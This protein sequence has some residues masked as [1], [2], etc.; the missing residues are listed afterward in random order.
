[1]RSWLVKSEPNCYSIDDLAKELSTPWSGV[2]NYQARNFMRDEMKIGDQVLF[3]HSILNPSVVGLAEVCSEPYPDPTQWNPD[4]EHFDPKSPAEK[5]RWYLVDV[6]FICKFNSAL[7][8]ADLRQY[9][10]LANM[11]LLRKGSRLSV[12]PVEQE[13][14]D[15]IL[16]LAK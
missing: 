9:P 4:D 1:M 13:A 16:N 5:P 3:Y 7:S 12:M 8:L 10:E 6:K 2:R 11:E 14:F 15:F